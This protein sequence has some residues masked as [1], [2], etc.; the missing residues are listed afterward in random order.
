LFSPDINSDNSI[1]VSTAAATAQANYSYMSVSAL[2]VAD[3]KTTIIGDITASGKATLKVGAAALIRQRVELTQDELVTQSGVNKMTTMVEQ[4]P[5]LVAKDA[6]VE[7]MKVIGETINKAIDSVTGL[8]GS[9]FMV[10]AGVVGLAVAARVAG[11]ANTGGGAGAGG[12]GLTPA[13]Q[14][15]RRA[16]RLSCG[17]LA[18]GLVLLVLAFSASSIWDKWYNPFSWFGVKDPFKITKEDY[19]WIALIFGPITWVA[20]YAYHKSTPTP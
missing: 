10:V 3:A 1:N 18:L 20:H 2:A 4:A 16:F 8:L 6:A 14:M 11:G 17:A 15:W 13:Q 5:K 12:D 19:W 9:P 7:G